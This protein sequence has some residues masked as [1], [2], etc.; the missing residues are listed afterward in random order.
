MARRAGSALVAILAFAAVAL[1]AA[2]LPTA[3]AA[4]SN[5]VPATVTFTGL[6]PQWATPG[7][8]ITVTGVV[9]NTAPVAQRLVVQLLDSG[10]PLSSVFELTQSAANGTSL[11]GL[12][13]P[14]AS[15]RST[16][17]PAGASAS[18]SMHVPVSVMGL[19][20]FGVYPLAAEVENGQ[21]TALNT[22]QTYLPY[23]PAK[24]GPYGSSIPAAQKLAWVW[25]LIDRPL[26]DEPWQSACTGSQAAALAQSLRPS[27]RLGQ[28]LTVA[29]SAAG[30][31]A[32]QAEELR[33]GAS[34]VTRSQLPG[35]EQAQSLASLDAITWAVDPALLANVTALARC[36]GAEPQWAQIASAWLTRLKAATDSQALFVTPY[37]DP[38]MAAL[39][40]SGHAPDLQK[41]FLYGRQQAGQILGRDLNPAQAGGQDQTASLAWA[42]DSAISY[43]TLEDLAAVNGVGTI[44]VDSS[45]FPAE[46]A[47]VLR[48]LDGGGSY[49]NLMLASDTLSNLLGSADGG[50]GS[51]FGTAQDFLAETALMAQTDPGAPIIVAPPQ[52]W[53][54]PAGLPA[55]GLTETA[56]A[57]WLS[58]APLTSLTSARNI[59]TVTVPT[60]AGG[61]G[62]GPVELGRLGALDT[63]VA[64]LQA[65]RAKPDPATALAVSTVE[66]SAYAGRFRATAFGMIDSLTSR[67]AGQQQR[68]RIVAE[69]RIT[70]GGNRGSVPVSVD[71]H[72]GYA[73]QVALN[74]SYDQ[75]GGSKIS[76][77]PPGLITVQ[78]HTAQTVRLRVTMTQTGSTTVTMTLANRYG[79]P[80]ATNPV[81][82]TVQTTQVGLLGMIIFALALG[83]FLIASAARAVRRSRPQPGRSD[84]GQPGHAGEEA[85]PDTVVSQDSELGAAGTPRP[86]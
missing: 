65:L 55:S 79:Q 80:L 82:M 13:L 7:A 69:N 57:P 11:A 54:P 71:N 5:Q 21:G 84:D 29:S 68:V 60:S 16:V 26:L 45:A 12:L 14:V 40:N 85:A 22:A 59:P 62:I 77:S 53:Q 37:G 4:A 83:V 63:A 50:T 70:L 56:S 73:V 19:T 27:G 64:Q 17:L 58:S 51:A 25:P 52:R 36:G 30:P 23:V 76:A 75:T 3:A 49:M 33:S 24:K 42:A 15:W 81:R 9:R 28:L 1:P 66:S 86:R 35:T 6:S 41:S 43:G 38:D 20:G 18:W 39:I 32:V 72:L 44:L 48:T 61:A 78:A 10:S 67:M 47:S 8:T 74:L 2:I 46:Q 31:A 34:H